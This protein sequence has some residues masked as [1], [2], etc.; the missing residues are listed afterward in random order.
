MI[1]NKNNYFIEKNKLQENIASICNCDYKYFLNKKNVVGIGLGYKVKNGFYT[2]QLCVQVFV[3]RKYSENEININDRIPS[4]YKGIL[5]DVKE[6]G[7]FKA[8]SLN[9]KIRPVLGGYSISVSTSEVINGTV[10]CLVVSGSYKFLL[11]T[12]HVLTRINVLPMKYPIIQPA[13]VYGGYAPTDTVATLD[14]F[15][16][17]RFIK[18]EQQPTNLTDCALG[19]LTK[20]NIMSNK[21][22]LIGKVS[23][24][25]N[26]KL[27]GNVKK[28]GEATEL[29]DG[30]ITSINATFTVSYANGELALFKD[31][32]ITTLM[33]MEGDSGAILVDDKD[34]AVGML[35]STSHNNTAFNRLSTVLDQ[36]DVHLPD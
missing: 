13:S 29:T 1:L 14:K 34:C 2:N 31:Q 28:V 12:N 9:K 4:M 26:P 22:A 16:P 18:G 5:T 10:G 19:L 11:S 36:L 21:I 30:I 24:V 27:F 32:I 20:P 15:I 23:C 3:S 6:T 25:K 7:Y 35:F 8:C 17:I 33:G